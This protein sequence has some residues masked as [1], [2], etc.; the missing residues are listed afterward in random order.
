M[1]KFIVWLL[2]LVMGL[3]LLAGCG[4]S[5]PAKQTEDQKE[6]AAVS[7]PAEEAGDESAEE[8]EEPADEASED[9]PL[10]AV[11][12]ANGNFGDNAYFD[13]N[14]AGMDRAGEELGIEVKS[15]EGGSELADFPAAIEALC[16]SHEYDVIITLT[17][18]TS[19]IVYN[20]AEKYPD[21]DF[22][23]IDDTMAALR[24]NIYNAQ[25]NQCEGSFLAGALAAL[26]T[27]DTDMEGVNAD[28][29]VGA[30]GNND[31]PVIRDFMDGFE[32]GVHYIDEDIEVL[33][34]FVGSATD[35]VKAKDLA[36]TMYSTQNVDVI[37][38]I[39]ASA[40][41]GIL[42]TAN[43][44]GKY[45]IGVDVNQNGLYPGAVLS[46]MLKNSGDGIFLAL[47]R[48]QEGTLPMGT[49]ELLSI[50]EG[51]IGLAKDEY[52]EQYVPAEIREQI[53][54]IEEKIMNGEIKVE[55]ELY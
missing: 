47:K 18:Q 38:N 17:A 49:T 14:K 3:S 43:E 34:A 10:K 39:A 48:Y 12:F 7:E 46:S 1:K 23:V 55:S 42:E 8:A 21:Q 9:K 13:G 36:Q 54:A 53:D 32:Q 37:F 28:K 5:K 44:V 35:V 11:F 31:V 6:E 20:L 26:V 52:Y 33:T 29:V 50:R 41:L 2:V 51:T 40:G 24:P 22:F 4:Q 16:E 45:A 19:E 27:T 25:Y 15:I 30:I